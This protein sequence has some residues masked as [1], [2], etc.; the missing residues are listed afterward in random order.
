MSDI[1]R[2]YPSI[3]SEAFAQSVEGAY[4]KRQFKFL[5]E[6]GRIGDLPSNDHLPVMTFWD[7][8]VSDS[9]VIWFIRKL[10]DTS[11]Q[12][13]DYY[14][15]SGEVMRHYFKVLKDRGYQYSEHYAPHDI[16]TAHL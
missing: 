6:N 16:Q 13:I 8:G 11:Y 12:V 1:K 9:M 2:E 5:Y 10:S 7:L 14:E 4:Y 3:P 15:N